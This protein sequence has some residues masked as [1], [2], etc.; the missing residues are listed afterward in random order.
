MVKSCNLPTR[1]HTRTTRWSVHLL[2]RLFRDE[3]W[4][5][6]SKEGS[7]F[8]SASHLNA[9]Y[10]SKSF[11][12]LNCICCIHLQLRFTKK[13]CTVVELVLVVILGINASRVQI[14]ADHG[15][16]DI[17]DHKCLGDLYRKLPQQVKHYKHEK[18]QSATKSKE[19]HKQDTHYLIDR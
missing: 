10:F 3:M 8:A 19:K 11:G 17:Q 16:M 15:H 6:S 18:H 12:D 13:I 14:V 5:Q 1:P 4:G 9:T 2:W 7:N